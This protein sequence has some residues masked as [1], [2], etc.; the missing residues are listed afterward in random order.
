M[1]VGLWQIICGASS[2]RGRKNPSS[3]DARPG[4]EWRSCQALVAGWQQLN[5]PKAPGEECRK[6]KMLSWQEA[7]ESAPRTRPAA[8]F[9]QERMHGVRNRRLPEKRSHEQKEAAA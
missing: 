1:G 8:E 6:R 9:H 7:E 3:G 5:R 2:L 4:A